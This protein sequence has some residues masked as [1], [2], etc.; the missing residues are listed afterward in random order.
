MTSGVGF[1]RLAGHVEGSRSFADAQDDKWGEDA[2]QN[3][4]YLP[5]LR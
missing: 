5:L 4:K 3:E 2:V 1:L